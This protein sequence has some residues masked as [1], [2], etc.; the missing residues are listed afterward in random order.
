MAHG[1][2][3]QSIPIVTA[4]NSLGIEGLKHALESTEA[5]AIFVDA[6]SISRVGAVF[7]SVPTLRF[8][9][10]D[11]DQDV[12]A[13]T[14]KE[15][16]RLKNVRFISYDDLYR[17]GQDTETPKNDPR[18]DNLF[19]IFYTSGST[20]VP[21]GV[22]MK[23]NNVVAAGLSSLLKVRQCSANVAFA[24]AGLDTVIG[25]HFNKEDRYLAYLPLAHVLEMAFE[26]ACLFWG[27]C[28]GYGT[29]KTLFDS[30][31]HDC[32]G[33]LRALRPTFV[34]GVPAIW[35]SVRKAIVDSVHASSHSK[36]D[37][38]RRALETRTKQKGCGVAFPPQSDVEE[39][40][41]ARDMLG[42]RLR[43]MLTGGGP[44]A[45][46]TQ[47]FISVVIAPLVNGFG[48]TETMAYVHP[49][50]HILGTQSLSQSPP[51]PNSANN[52]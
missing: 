1:A 5:V 3:S 2:A 31:T 39:F 24:V 21:K 46:A 34:L 29:P 20:G 33:D 32:K 47:K 36:K 43:F 44:T 19:A 35:E 26:H 22:P 45:A 50:R 16:P 14:V 4:Y 10:Y 37:R 18:P 40:N 7:D 28:I 6:N 23:H 15:H 52:E 13:Q 48:L 27:V 9:V 8:V 38:F 12:L 51:L 42:G 11:G 30:S 17:L 25:R 49:M 41:D